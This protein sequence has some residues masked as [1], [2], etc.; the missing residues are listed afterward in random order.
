MKMRLLMGL[1]LA[2]YLVVVGCVVWPDGKSRTGTVEATTHGPIGPRAKLEGLPLRGVAIQLSNVSN[3]DIYKQAIDEIAAIGEQIGELCARAKENKLRIMLMPIVLLERPRGNEWRGT[4]K[5]DWDDWF[6]SYREM[7]GHYAR[8]AEKNKV[9]LLVVGSELVSTES[10]MNQW[11]RTINMVRQNYRGMLTYSS[12]WDH[13]V[14]IP[15]WDQLD[16]IGMN[17]YWKLGDDR[18]VPV[19][20]IMRRWKNIQK[21][22]MAF[23]KRKGKPIILVEVGWC[24]IGNAPY[25]P[26]DYTKAEEPLDLDVQR[27]LYEGFFRSWYGNPNMA[28]FMIWEWEPGAPGGPTNRSY[29]PKGKPAEKVLREW[30]GKGPWEVN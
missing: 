21:D 7:M 26:W 2:A 1:A 11:T 3:L 19:E 29:T 14:D 28:G 10:Q 17:S 12:N 24:S 22:L 8:I 30:L 6:D 9:D 13:Y 16:V 18:H 25:E 15:F 4:I 5:P 20:E 23:S 27:R